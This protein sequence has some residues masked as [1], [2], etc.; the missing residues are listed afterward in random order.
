MGLDDLH[1]Y[2]RKRYT[3]NGEAGVL[4]EIFAR[5]GVTNRYCVEFGCEDASECNTAFL[6]EHGW[7]GLLMDPGGLSRNP[8]AVVRKE[9]VTAENVNDLFQ[10]YGVPEA[11]DLLSIDI[12][13]NDYWVW[14]A[15]TYRPRV[16]VIEY[17]AH[18]PPQ[19]PGPSPTTRPS[20]GTARTTSAPACSRWPNWD[21]ARATP[22]STARAPAPT[23]S[24]WPRTFCPRVSSRGRWRPVPAA[25]LPGAGAARH[26]PDRARA[27]T[28][29]TPDPGD[30]PSRGP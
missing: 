1:R 15:I 13:G 10:K 27:M 25:Q 4:A 26:P 7:Q 8:W 22:W 24:S 12:D 21:M 17:N 11:F 23:P 28:D 19:E 20:A 18:V 30:S 14:R 16:V 2:E 29:P 3:Q 9:L 5:V 6:L